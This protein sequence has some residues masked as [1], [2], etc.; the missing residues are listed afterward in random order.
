MITL[1][2]LRCNYLG[3]NVIKR[4]RD[5][6]SLQN[7][8][9]QTLPAGPPPGPV[10]PLGNPKAF[11]Y[12]GLLLSFSNPELR[13]QQSLVRPQGSFFTDFS[14]SQTERGKASSH[15]LPSSLARQS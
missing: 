3:M 12:L 14:P 15:S 5:H 7:Q 10:N 11:A 4:A 1:P 9:C 2:P 6:P 13:S 8:P